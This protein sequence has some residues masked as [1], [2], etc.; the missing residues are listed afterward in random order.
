MNFYFSLKVIK[1]K[2]KKKWIFGKEKK[3]I[4]PEKN[5]DWTTE[6]IASLKCNYT[7]SQTAEYL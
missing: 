5:G 2:E 3:K 6:K 7:S 4:A 1:E